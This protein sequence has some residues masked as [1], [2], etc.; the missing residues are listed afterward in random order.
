MVDAYGVA[1]GEL[2]AVDIPPGPAWIEVVHRCWTSGTALLPLDARMRAAERAAILERARPAAVLD[3]EG[4]TTVF[5]GQQ[6]VSPDIALVVA[7]SGT[8]GEPR[9]AELS[10]AGVEAAVEGSARALAGAMGTWVACLPPS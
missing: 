5:A 10:R 6:P 4:E 2:L 9:L 7:T 3:T 1:P 8:G